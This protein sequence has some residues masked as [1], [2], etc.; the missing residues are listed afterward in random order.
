MSYTVLYPNMADTSLSTVN[1]GAFPS[2]V[3]TGVTSDQVLITASDYTNSTL[4]VTG[5]ATIS[6]DLTIKGRN[7]TSI[8]DSIEERLALLNPNPA[9]EEKWAEL[10]RIRNEYIA[11]EKEIQE[12]EQMWNKLKRNFN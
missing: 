10:R 4:T 1:T 7:L 5:S 12:K 2:V 8:L 6:G 9:L 11:M 3:T